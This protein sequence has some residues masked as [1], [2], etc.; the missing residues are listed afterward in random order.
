MQGTEDIIWE[1]PLGRYEGI[2]DIITYFNLFCLFDGLDFKIIQEVHSEGKILLDWEHSGSFRGFTHIPWLNFKI[3]MKT[4]IL[5]KLSKD[6]NEERIFTII[7]EWGGN[8]LLSEENS[9]ILGWIHK[10]MRI[11]AG[12]VILTFA[13]NVSYV[14]CTIK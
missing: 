5:L 12:S 8:K 7:E 2:N 10:K 4:H 13:R 11:F 9:P 1:D 6:L 14:F 3:R